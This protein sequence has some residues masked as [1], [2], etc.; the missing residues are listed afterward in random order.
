[1]ASRKKP[2]SK[3]TTDSNLEPKEESTKN[4]LHISVAVPSLSGIDAAATAAVLEEVRN[5][6][7]KSIND[8]ELQKSLDTWVK[9]NQTQHN[10]QE[11]D[12]LLLKSVIT[13]YLDSYILFGY[14]TT[15]ERIIVQHANNSRDRDAIM[16]F[17][18]TIFIQQQQNN[19][20]D[21]ESD[22]DEEDEEE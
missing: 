1:M 4:R 8:A 13:E 11:R 2:T 18:K 3:K 16:E 19:F 5:N 20:L 21:L 17:L 12:Y 9:E 7:F 10:I 15:G 6:I 22:I 14:D